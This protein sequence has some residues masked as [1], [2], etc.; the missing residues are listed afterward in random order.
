MCLEIAF[1]GWEELGG[2]ARA[3]RAGNA[4]ELMAGGSV[5][6][7][8]SNDFFDDGWVVFD[9]DLPLVFN[10]AWPVSFHVF[11]NGLKFRIHIIP[12]SLAG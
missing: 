9:F 4:D 5:F 10:L 2:F 8:E 1:N 3:G 6:G 11:N 7:L 12:L